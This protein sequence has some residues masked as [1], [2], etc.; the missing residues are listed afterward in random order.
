MGTPGK[1]DQAHA[2]MVLIYP[3]AGLSRRH[4]SPLATMTDS[5]TLPDDLPN[6]IRAWRDRPPAA[7]LRGMPKVAVPA[8]GVVR[9]LVPEHGA[10]R[11]LALFYRN[12]LRLAPARVVLNAAS[13]ANLDELRAR[14]LADAQALALRLSRRDLGWAAGSGTLLGIAGAAGLA[15][16]AP[17]LVLLSMRL[18]I[19]TGYCYGEAPTPQL[20]AALFALASADT[21]EE[22]QLAW[23][24]ALA[25]RGGHEVGAEIADEALRDGL[26]RAAEREFAKQALSSSLNRLSLNLVQ[27]L[28][29][30]KVAGALPL[31]G[32][33][34]GGAVN[35]R[36]LAQ[37]AVAARM[38]FAARR[39][40]A[41]GEDL[42]GP[43]PAAVAASAPPPARRR[44]T[45]KPA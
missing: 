15:A 38:V 27:R 25:A 44:R 16:D 37:L 18:L 36:F 28:G 39:L 7:E 21:V 45:R 40:A 31:I 14:P 13:A 22:K 4:R 20:A 32:A 41:Q 8:V 9:R 11:L 35:A 33:A 24:S 30:R 3:H 6:A 42:L 43:K 26:E 10:Q 34:V 19:R 23:R 17:A 5:A 2:G 1:S 29:W 12:A